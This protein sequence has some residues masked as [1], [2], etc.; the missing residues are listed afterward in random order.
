MFSKLQYTK[1]CPDEKFVP[2]P[3]QNFPEDEEDAPE[4]LE[5]CRY[6]AFWAKHTLIL[7]FGIIIGLGLSMTITTSIAHSHNHIAQF[8]SIE[9]SGGSILGSCGSSPEEALDL[10][11]H[12]DMMSSTWDW[13]ECHDHELLQE[14]VAEQNLTWYLDKKHTQAIS[15]DIAYSGNFTRLYPLMDFHISHCVY[16]WRKMHKAVLLQAPLDE[17]LWSYEHT[18]HCS[19]LIMDWHK[20]R[21]T[22][23]RSMPGY[24]VCRKYFQSG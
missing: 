12:Y 24:P 10:G 16:M 3:A 15:Q 13:P 14:M 18:L 5:K 23:S 11:C 6:T 17:E 2:N 22:I 1:V 19:R 8:S 7:I 21:K 9:N 4:R 20:P